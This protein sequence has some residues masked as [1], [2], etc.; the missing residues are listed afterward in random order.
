MTD[1]VV[2]LAR[3]RKLP[4]LW[5]GRAVEWGSWHGEPV[6]L[7]CRGGP[8]PCHGCGLDRPRAVAIGKGRNAAGEWRLL[9]AHRCTA[10]GADRVYDDD[11][12]KL[13]ELDDDDYGPSGSYPPGFRR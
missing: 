12:G 7:C 10:C 1:G 3:P 6:N 9:V 5:D 8:D 2:P 11:T 13:W 4:R